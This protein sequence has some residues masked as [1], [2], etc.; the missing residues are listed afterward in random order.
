MDDVEQALRTGDERELTEVWELLHERRMWEHARACART[1]GQEDHERVADQALSKVVPVTALQGLTANAR[2]VDLLVG[3]RW[4]V[5]QQAREDGATW[6]EIGAA[7]GMARQS[8][9]EWYRDRI[10]AQERLGR[11]YNDAARERAALEDS[12]EG[13]ER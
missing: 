7:L 5:M 1:R 12:G 9:W 6:E 4:I 11:E 2:L 13:D 10:D 8:A 3:R